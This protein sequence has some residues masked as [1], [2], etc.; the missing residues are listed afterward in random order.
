MNWVMSESLPGS[1][2][3]LIRLSGSAVAFP[4]ISDN[5]LNRAQAD[6]LAAKRTEGI[7]AN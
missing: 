4:G 7:R 2:V 3:L 5:G 6:E 1:R